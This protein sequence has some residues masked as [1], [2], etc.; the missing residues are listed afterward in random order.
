MV[1]F[2]HNPT[3]QVHYIL[4]P[5]SW[6]PKTLIISKKWRHSGHQN[7]F[8]FKKMMKFIKLW[9]KTRQSGDNQVTQIIFFTKNLT[10]FLI[11]FNSKTGHLMEL[12]LLVI[13]PAKNK[14]NGY[15][16]FS[17]SDIKSHP[18]KSCLRIGLVLPFISGQNKTKCEQGWRLIVG[19]LSGSDTLKYADHL[20][21]YLV[22][23]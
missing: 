1:H 23:D 19:K 13:S 7:S 9:P 21:S 2:P 18:Q 11:Q 14:W 12:L 6:H 22:N 20:A 10:F 4:P 17:L 15:S 3:L 5:F 16:S 8:R